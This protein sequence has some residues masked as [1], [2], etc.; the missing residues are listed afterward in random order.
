MLSVLPFNMFKQWSNLGIPWRF[1][2]TALQWNYFQVA[3]YVFNKKHVFIRLSLSQNTIWNTSFLFQTV[4]LEVCRQTTLVI[5]LSL[6]GEH[7]IFQQS[8]IARNYVLCCKFSL[9][10]LKWSGSPLFSSVFSSSPLSL[11]IYSTISSSSSSVSLWNSTII[12]H[13]AFL[14]FWRCLHF[15]TII[16][17]LFLFLFSIFCFH[18]L[19]NKLVLLIN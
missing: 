5:S 3:T 17:V 15:F 14:T 2:G 10:S 4:R 18:S 19:P 16:F 12:L 1:P 7:E 13:F 8:S 6:L 9:S 11:S